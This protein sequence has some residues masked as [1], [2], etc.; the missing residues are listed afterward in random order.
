MIL[1]TRLFMLLS[2]LLAS[3][4]LAQ[5]SWEAV[6]PGG[7]HYAVERPTLHP[8][9]WETELHQSYDCRSPA[10]MIPFDDR[11]SALHLRYKWAQLNP[12]DGVYD[13]DDL[14]GVIDE[15]RASGK[16]VTLNIMAGKYTPSWVFDAGAG[17]IGTP[18]KTG[19]RYSQ[20]L[21]PLPWDAVF[22]Q[23]YRDLI[24][25]LA[26]HLREVEDRYRAVALV[27]NGAIVV[28][29]GETRLMPLDAFDIKIDKSHQAQTDTVRAHLCEDWAMAGYSED[30]VLSA[31][32][33]TTAA[34]A[35][36][37]P[38][39]YVGLAYVGGSVQ[40][41]TVNNSGIC[42]Y[43]AKNQTTNLL[44][45]QMVNDYGPRAIINNTVLTSKIGNPPIMDWVSKHGGKVAY[46]IN[47]QEIGCSKRKPDGCDLE[48]FEQA[49]DAGISNNAVYIEIHDGNVSRYG[50]ILPSYNARLQNR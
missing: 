2:T 26:N 48:H 45:K 41:P 7:I 1:F 46:Q 33:D 10:C 42:T 31:A 36:A 4:A 11:I 29:S 16:L 43:P 30:L 39:Q 35:Q 8:D 24:K 21:V 28:H 38:D 15:A 9:Q 14:N 27:K 40:F 32:R 50:D 19:D 12:A 20:P 47:Q 22:L 17:H 23:S 18:A 37:F 49:L 34:I 6:N 5:E 44:I 25:A 3:S 13:F